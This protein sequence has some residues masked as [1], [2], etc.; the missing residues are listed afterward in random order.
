MLH[1]TLLGF[2]LWGFNLFG[3]R[4]ARWNIPDIV[5][6]RVSR[7]AVWLIGVV[8]ESIADQQLSDFVTTRLIKRPTAIWRRKPGNYAYL[9]LKVTGVPYAEAQS[10]KS[11]G[12]LYRGLSKTRQPLCA[13]AAAVGPVVKNIPLLQLIQKSA[14]SSHR[15]P[16][17]ERVS[18][19]RN[20]T[21]FES[22][23]IFSSE[24]LASRL[25]IVA[26]RGISSKIAA[27]GGLDLTDA[28]L[29][30]FGL[31]EFVRA[32]SKLSLRSCLVTMR[33]LCC[34]RAAVNRCAINTRLS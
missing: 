2:G 25:K 14:R 31:S 16:R 6:G 9:L 20:P 7:I 30:R 15:P 13:L 1:L 19:I 3:S 32:K 18:L 33:W 29:A 8:G 17:H 10:L 27:K 4:I 11:K 23:R 24:I 28:T 22:P 5:V 12:D 26:A 21:Y 34:P